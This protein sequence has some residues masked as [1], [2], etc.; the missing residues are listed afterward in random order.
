MANNVFIEP[1]KVESLLFV[2]QHFAEDTKT[3]MENA[4]NHINEKMDYF[5]S[6]EDKLQQKVDE[7]MAKLEKAQAALTRC[8][9]SQRW[10][11]EDGCYKPSCSSEAGQVDKYKREVDKWKAKLEE[12]K[13]IIRDCESAIGIYRD[14]E[15]SMNT[16]LNEHTPA[17]EIRMQHA[18][19]KGRDIEN[20]NSLKGSL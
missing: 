7:A 10:D 18:V 13:A 14:K 16:L 3:E 19:Q 9:N 5:H 6:V 20:V 15:R 8:E 17:L 2:F 11:E 12:C 1:D 4:N